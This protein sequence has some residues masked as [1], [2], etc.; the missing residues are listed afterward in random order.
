VLLS[1]ACFGAGLRLT[2][3]LILHSALA[4]PA[5]VADW[6]SWAVASSRGVVAAG[7]PSSLSYRA[8]PVASPD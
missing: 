3:L 5:R 6:L 4:Y 7:V 8:R 2:L 1:Q